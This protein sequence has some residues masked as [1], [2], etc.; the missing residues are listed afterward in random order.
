ME[1]SEEILEKLKVAVN[2]GREFWEKSGTLPLGYVTDIVY[3][4]L[5]DTLKH[6]LIEK[7]HKVGESKN[8]IVIH[9]TN[10]DALVSMLQ[11]T[12]NN[13]SNKDQEGDKN[14]E[15]MPDDENFYLRLYDSVYLN[16]PDE[17][18]YFNRNLNLP[19]KYN[20]IKEKDVRH[21]YVTS[22]ILP[23]N[24][25]DRENDMSD[26]LIFWRT[27]GQE[28][29]GCSLSLYVPCSRLQKVLYGPEEVKSTAEALMPIL[30]LLDPLLEIDDSSIRE[31]LA[32]TVWEALERIRYLYKSKAY[33]Y[34][35]ECRFVLLESDI[36]KNK[37]R[38]E[39]QDRNN[40]PA[41]IRHYY[42]HE[43]LQVKNILGSGSS[44][45]FGPSIPIDYHDNLRYCMEE[46]KRR[47]GS[48]FA[49]EIKFSDITYRKS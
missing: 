46:L 47:I 24:V 20:W 40:S 18:N 49:P 37:I 29:E 10:I 23:D 7:R 8:K 4:P 27:Y 14:S 21:A 5:E 9:Y 1:Q 11:N 15:P 36:D 42:E 33:R 13:V 26:D 48:P 44:I 28:G 43:A 41:R 34:E 38:F 35:Q 45:T 22:F 25:P 2:S 3:S 19:P 39:Y 6:L 32:E 16:D 30:D 31:Q 17:G 12:S